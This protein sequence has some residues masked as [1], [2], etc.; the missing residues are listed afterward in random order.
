MYKLEVE[1]KMLLFNSLRH[2]GEGLV[3]INKE[4]HIFKDVYMYFICAVEV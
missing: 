1:A 2:L 3:E 4:K